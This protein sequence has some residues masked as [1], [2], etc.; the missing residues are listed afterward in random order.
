M[1]DV[2]KP[3]RLADGVTVRYDGTEDNRGWSALSPARH[4]ADAG[5][6]DYFGA[7]ADQLDNDPQLIQAAAMYAAMRQ[8]S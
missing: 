5:A 2:Y 8:D 3:R 4:E 7:D 6:P 1:D